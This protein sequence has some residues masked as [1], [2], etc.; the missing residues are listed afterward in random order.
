MDFRIKQEKEDPGLDETTRV[1]VIHENSNWLIP[2]RQAFAEL[3]VPYEEWFINEGAV[4]LGRKPPHGIFYNR[5]SASSHIRDHR[6][7]VEFAG[8]VLAW[9]EANGRRLINDRRALQM[10]IC[11]SEQMLALSSWGFRTPKTIAASGSNEILQAA[12]ELSIAPF[13][14]KPNRGGSGTGVQLFHSIDQLSRILE[15]EGG[16]LSLDGV[17]IIQEYIKPVKSRIVRLEFIGGEFFYAVSVDTSGGFELCPADACEAG[18]AFCPAESGDEEGALRFRIIENYHNPE[19]RRY[20]EF[21]ASLGLEIAAIEYVE[22]EKGERFVFDVN[23]NTN[24]NSKAESASRSNLRG[25]HQIAGFLKVEL[26]KLN[27]QDY[28]KKAI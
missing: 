14:I 23:M 8:P 2:L 27:D 17:C 26:M 1:Y 22:N 10:E 24:Y 4:D 28:L 18:H 12:K 7:A 3:D 21:L 11:K 20:E 5:M 25:M 19:I 16:I 6:F 15:D 13:I 9:L